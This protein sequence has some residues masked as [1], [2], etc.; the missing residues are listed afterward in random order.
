MDDTGWEFVKGDDMV[1]IGIQDHDKAKELAIKELG[2]EPDSEAKAVPS[3]IITF[4]QIGRGG[5]VRGRVINR[6]VM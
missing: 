1:W 4:L 3:E 6:G 5:V 2:G